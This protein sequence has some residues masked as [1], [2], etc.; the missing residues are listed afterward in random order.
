MPTSKT[1]PARPSRAA[2]MRELRLALFEVRNVEEAV[3]HA[4]LRE[5]PARYVRPEEYTA[6]ARAVRRWAD[7]WIAL[8]A[9][10]G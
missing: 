8:E 4:L 2:A 3:R 1:A 5:V 7:A 6:A 9:R 10:D